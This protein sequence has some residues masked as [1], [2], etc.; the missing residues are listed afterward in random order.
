MIVAIFA[1]LLAIAEALCRLS[2][3]KHSSWQA[4]VLWEGDYYTHTGKTR[5][6]ALEWMA[7]YPK[8]SSAV[9]V[10]VFRGNSTVQG[11]RYA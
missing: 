9:V 1:G 3:R 8:G 4:V 10:S 7:C 5:E 2:D 6:E 11:A